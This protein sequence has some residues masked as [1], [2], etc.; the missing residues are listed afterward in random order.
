MTTQKFNIY[1]HITGLIITAIEEGCA[2]WRKPWTGGKT[3]ASLPL[4]HNGEPYRGI[5][6][7]VLW[8]IRSDA[9]PRVASFA[10]L[11]IVILTPSS[12]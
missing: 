9:G 10:L 11:A 12:L 3:G 1:D 6:T 2:P 4:R 8:A 5:N 7:L